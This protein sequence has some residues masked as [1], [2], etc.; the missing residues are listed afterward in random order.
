MIMYD[1]RA[2]TISSHIIFSLGKKWM[3]KW[4]YFNFFC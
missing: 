1:K 3:Y 2:D 4:N